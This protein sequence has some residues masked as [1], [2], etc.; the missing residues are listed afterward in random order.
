MWQDESNFVGFVQFREYILTTKN[1][2]KNT[3]KKSPVVRRHQWHHPISSLLQ[4]V[5]E[6]ATQSGLNKERWKSVNGGLLHGAFSYLWSLYFISI[7][8][9]RSSHLSEGISKK[10]PAV[11][12]SPE[13]NL[14]WY[15]RVRMWELQCSVRW[16]KG[17]P[18]QC[19]VIS[20]K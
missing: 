2:N 19:P 9:N 14:T 11:R 3:I 13:R 1:W 4:Q 15:K 6:T 5:S 16:I 20:P 7:K 8:Q 18:G 12:S 10:I 17:L